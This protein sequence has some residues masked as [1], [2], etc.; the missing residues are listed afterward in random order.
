VPTVANTPSSSSPP[1]P[2]KEQGLSFSR[3]PYVLRS[4]AGGTTSPACCVHG[5]LE[6]HAMMHVL[7]QAV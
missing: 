5:L 2:N 4:M 7:V 3:H 6:A 1:S